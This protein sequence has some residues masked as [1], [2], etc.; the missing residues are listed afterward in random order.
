MLLDSKSR[1]ASYWL[2]ESFLLLARQFGISSIVVGRMTSHRRRGT[3]GTGAQA[4]SRRA[5]AGAWGPLDVLHQG[6]DQTVG[7]RGETAV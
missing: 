3:F 5:K 4:S 1:A 6:E 2:R 7:A